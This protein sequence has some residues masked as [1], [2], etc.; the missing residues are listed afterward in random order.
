MTEAQ[1]NT[2]ETQQLIHK[3]R[4]QRF[5]ITGGVDRGKRIDRVNAISEDKKLCVKRKD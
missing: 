4:V 3:R 1:P 2:I 5:S